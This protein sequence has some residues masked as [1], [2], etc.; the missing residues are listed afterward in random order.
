MKRPRK[1]RP[2]RRRQPQRVGY[3][4]RA[5][6]CRAA[7]VGRRNRICL[8]DVALSECSGVGFR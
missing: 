2:P 6:G 8:S 7:A 4:Y 1:F 3:R 5:A